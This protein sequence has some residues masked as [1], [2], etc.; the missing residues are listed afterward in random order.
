MHHRWHEGLVQRVSLLG[1]KSKDTKV[2]VVS[3][4]IERPDR[5]PYACFGKKALCPK[6]VPTTVNHP[7]E[8]RCILPEGVGANLP[9]QELILRDLPHKYRQIHSLLLMT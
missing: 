3:I 6:L 8:E 5:A 2:L 9:M 7:G 4:S 1:S